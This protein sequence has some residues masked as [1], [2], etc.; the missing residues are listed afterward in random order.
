MGRYHDKHSGPLHR[1]KMND[2]DIPQ[3]EEHG[4]YSHGKKEKSLKQGAPSPAGVP[5]PVGG[6]KAEKHGK[7]SGAGGDTDA[8]DNG[9]KG[10]RCARD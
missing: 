10:N 5:Q 7:Q 9:L 1:K 2:P 4:G 3:P 8:V 6:N